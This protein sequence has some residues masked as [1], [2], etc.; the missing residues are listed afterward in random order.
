MNRIE[1]R[2]LSLERAEL[3]RSACVDSCVK[4]MLRRDPKL[5]SWLCG[6]LA[7]P[8]PT[9]G[10]VPSASSDRLPENLVEVEALLTEELR[11]PEVRIWVKQLLLDAVLA[12]GS[13][14]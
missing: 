2:L 13:L 11:V 6:L 12:D 7:T 5:R 10:E 1:S 3:Q 4:N 8:A 9:S 14:N